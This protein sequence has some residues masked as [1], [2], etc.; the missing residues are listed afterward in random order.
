MI[1]R[2]DEFDRLLT[3]HA[4]AEDV[5]GHVADADHGNWRCRDVDIHFAEVPFHCLPRAARGYADLLVVVT[6]RAARGEGIAEPE[7]M[8]N[9]QFVGDIG[10]CGGALVRGN[11]E[12]WIVAIVANEIRRRDHAGRSLSD[13]VGDIEQR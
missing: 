6:G 7:I 3:Q 5:A 8:R 11:H 9:R 12:V 10:E 1:E 13:I 4:V 2:G